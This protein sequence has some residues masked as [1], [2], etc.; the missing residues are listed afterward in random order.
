M[1]AEASEHA[2]ERPVGRRSVGRLT[3][4]NRYS[5]ILAKRRSARGVHLQVYV[6]ESV[7]DAAMLG[8]GVSKAIAKH[9]SA[10]N[11]MRRAVRE[12]LRQYGPQLVPRE[13]VIL[14]R[15]AFDRHA[16]A[17]V[18]AELDKLLAQLQLCAAR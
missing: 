3:G 5:A 13:L 11:Y 17:Q 16:R 18:A 4:R 6:G 12:D 8:V 15:K 9:A 1:Q 7:K 14:V 10:R 2:K